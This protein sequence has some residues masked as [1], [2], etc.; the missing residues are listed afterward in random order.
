MDRPGT[1][2]GVKKE[3]DKITPVVPKKSHQQEG[4]IWLA[5]N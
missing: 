4:S 5:E 2:L 3:L 1:S